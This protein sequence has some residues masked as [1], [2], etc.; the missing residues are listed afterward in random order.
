MSF[1]SLA[2][3]TS[4]HNSK[5]YFSKYELNKILSCY[6]LG[7]EKGYWKD[8]SINFRPNEA[9]FS[10]YKNSLS[11]P[12]YSLVKYKLCKKLK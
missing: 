12:V 1:I 5:L 3:S 4:N 9:S 8:Y 6:A 11:L 10:I 2:S 7:V